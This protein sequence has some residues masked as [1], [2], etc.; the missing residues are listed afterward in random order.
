[1]ASPDRERNSSEVDKRDV[2][3]AGGSHGLRMARGVGKAF[4]IVAMLA[5]LALFGLVMVKYSPFNPRDLPVGEHHP[6]VGKQITRL[7]LVPLTGSAEAVQ[8]ADLA[9]RVTLMNF[10]GTWCPPCR[11]EFPHM[12]EI[13]EKFRGRPDFLFLS[14]S[15]GGG[16][17]EDLDTLRADTRGFLAGILPDFPTYADPELETRKEVDRVAG[18][19]GYPTTLVLD[20]S[21]TIRAVWVGY[22][23]G[24]EREITAT[25]QKLLDGR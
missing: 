15:C 5:L 14:V 2:P 19:K 16:P 13:F 20:K 4:R 1:M 18:F 24:L 7:A 17:G 12:R 9:G 25:L 21:G 22:W 8:T 6:A 10:W 23:P 3:E 11:E